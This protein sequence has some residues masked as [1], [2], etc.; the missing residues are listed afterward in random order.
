MNYSVDDLHLFTLNVGLA[1]HC[2]DWNWKNI[3]SPFARLYYVTEGRANIML[4]SG[5]YTLRPDYLYLIPA[6][7]THSY[8][9]DSPFS[10][11]YIHIYEGLQASRSILDKWII[12]VEVKAERQDLDLVKRLCEMNP[13][14]QLSHSDP[15]TY[16]NHQTLANNLQINQN[17]PFADK[18]E[19]RGIIFILLSRFLNKAIPNNHVK[20]NRIQQI[21]T[22]IQ[23]H[24]H[25]KIEVGQ[26]SDMAFM[27]KDHFIRIFKRETGDTPTAYII[28]RKMEK[29]EMMLLTTNMPIKNISDALG[30]TDFSYFNKTFKMN[31]GTTPQQYRK[32][33]QIV[34]ADAM[35][36]ST[37]ENY[38]INHRP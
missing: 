33:N 15:D 27:S 11:Y 14:F 29:A 13:F 28:K 21:I 10:H 16:D 37:N 30:Y 5:M 3:R 2:S 6:F 4:P 12:P 1:R 18:V 17:R 34:S 8:F 25:Q 23:D 26:L 32:V 35:G 19:S 31:V 20:D 24:I 38:F 9:C 22:Y 7:T 36:S